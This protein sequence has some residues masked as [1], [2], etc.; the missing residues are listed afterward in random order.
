MI[1]FCGDI[2]RHS[3]IQGQYPETVSDVVNDGGP[4]IDAIKKIIETFEQGNQ[5]N[6]FNLF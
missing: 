1:V 2:N 4:L 5:T 3:G 6:G